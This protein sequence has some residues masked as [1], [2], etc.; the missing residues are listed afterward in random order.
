MKI[1]MTVSVDDTLG[2]FIESLTNNVLIPQKQ[3]RGGGVKTTSKKLLLSAP[4]TR[5][6][7]ISSGIASTPSISTD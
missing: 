4:F 2:N 3:T 5:R 7:L 1:D 6:S